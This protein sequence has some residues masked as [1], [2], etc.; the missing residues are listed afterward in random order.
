LSWAASPKYQ[1]NTGRKLPRFSAS[2]EKQARGAGRSKFGTKA[3]EL[4]KEGANLHLE[5]CQR[6]VAPFE[7]VGETARLARLVRAGT[8]SDP[9]DWC[10]DVG[11]VE[12]D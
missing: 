4:G 12:V 9:E 11:L 5:D 8:A 3:G 1:A 7:K 6:E 10:Q 2:N